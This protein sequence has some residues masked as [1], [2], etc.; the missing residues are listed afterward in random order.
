MDI[1]PE[2]AIRATIKLG[3][4]YY[5]PE[6]T[7]SSSEPHYFIVINNNPHEDS[8]IFLV[9]SSSQIEK[10]RERHKNCPSET[11][12]EIRPEQYGGFKVTSIIDCNYVMEKSINK[13]IE[14][15]SIGEL[16][17]K[18][19][20]DLVIVNQLRNGVLRSRIVEKRIKTLLQD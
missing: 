19:E 20:M 5:F 8:I 7:F 10:T 6:E 15:L 17:I 18:E 9:C 1:P 4:V 3:S 2:V 11:M 14:K 13:L 16:K 12:V